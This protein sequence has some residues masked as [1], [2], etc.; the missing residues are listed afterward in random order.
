MSVGCLLEGVSGEFLSSVCLL[1]CEFL[2]MSV[3]GREVLQQSFWTYV[4]A[5]MVYG[6]CGVYGKGQEGLDDGIRRAWVI[7]TCGRLLAV[8]AYHAVAW[9][10]C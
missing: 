4:H 7:W 10:C 5:C 9:G 6:V 8:V 2:R 3:S 1:V